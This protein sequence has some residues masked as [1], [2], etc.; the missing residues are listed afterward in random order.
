MICSRLARLWRKKEEIASG[1]PL[2]HA[3]KLGFFQPQ[4]GKFMEFD[5]PVPKDFESFLQKVA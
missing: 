1:R 5:S 2:L 4:T 3:Q